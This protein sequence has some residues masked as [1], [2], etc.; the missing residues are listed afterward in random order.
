MRNM[1]C[2]DRVWKTTC[3]VET[4][5]V[6]RWGHHLYGS[7]IKLAFNTEPYDKNTIVHFTMNSNLAQLP[8]LGMPTKVYLFDHYYIIRFHK[9]QQK[10]FYLT[11]I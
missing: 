5:I 4:P 1:S 6:K 10:Y 9:C 11:T 3:K 8:E 2:C 7:S